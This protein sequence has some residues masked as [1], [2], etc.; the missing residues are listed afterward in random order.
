MVIA[1][2]KKT[3]LAGNRGRARLYFL[4]SS[5]L[6]RCCNFLKLLPWFRHFLGIFFRFP[7]ILCPSQWYWSVLEAGFEPICVVSFHQGNFSQVRWALCGIAMSMARQ[8]SVSWACG[9]LVSSV[10]WTSKEQKLL[11]PRLFSKPK[12]KMHVHIRLARTRNRLRFF[13]P[14]PPPVESSCSCPSSVAKS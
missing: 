14:P 2:K 7:L 6:L 1:Q 8:S 5:T 4:L 9:S 10:T 12:R 13:I 11:L 3:N